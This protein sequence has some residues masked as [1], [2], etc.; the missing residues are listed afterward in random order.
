M[1]ATELKVQVEYLK[2]EL[3]KIKADALKFYNQLETQ[4]SNIE[5][6]SINRAMGYAEIIGNAKG[7]LFIISAS[8]GAAVYSINNQK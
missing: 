8:A 4:F 1:E 2:E 5:G 7:S 3:E 6:D